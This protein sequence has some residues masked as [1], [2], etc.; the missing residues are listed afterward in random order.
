M[1]TGKWAILAGVLAL[2]SAVPAAAQDRRQYDPQVEKWAAA[3]VSAR[4]GELRGT[5]R[6]REHVDAVTAH[7]VHSRPPARPRLLSPIFVLPQRAGDQ[8]PPIVM[9]VRTGEAAS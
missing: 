4:L 2:A 6:L 8:L 3:Q 7:D 5:F 9:R 1:V